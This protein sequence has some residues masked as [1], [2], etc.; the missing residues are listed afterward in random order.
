MKTSRNKTILIDSR[1][2]QLLLV[3]PENFI[4]NMKYPGCISSKAVFGSSKIRLGVIYVSC[5]C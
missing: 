3:S 4:L 1:G 2:T 5:V